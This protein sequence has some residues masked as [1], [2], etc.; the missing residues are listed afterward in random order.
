[1]TTLT[2]TLSVGGDPVT[3]SLWLE[4]SQRA[5]GAGGLNVS[6]ADPYVFR[7]VAGQIAG[8]GSAPYTV[9]GNDTLTP[10]NTWYHVT[11]FGADGGQLLRAS[12]SIT[13]ASADIG[14]FPS[15]STGVFVPP[16][17]YGVALLG[18]AVGLST[19]NT[20]TKIRGK[21]VEAPPWTPGEVMTVQPDGSLGFDPPSGGGGGGGGGTPSGTVVSETA[22]GGS[23]SA[24]SASTYS[25]GDHTH[26]TP[27]APTP[28]SIGAAAASHTHAQADV[29][30]L[31]SDLSAKAPLAS[32]TFTGTPAAPTASVGTNTTQVATTAF[33]QAAA[34]AMRQI[35]QNSQSGAYVVVASDAGKHVYIS[36]GGVTLNASV[37]SAGDAVTIVNNSGSNQTITAGASVTFRLAGT[38]TTG[39]R[40]LAQYGVATFLCVV[41]GA[42]PTYVCTGAGLS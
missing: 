19:S 4:L 5:V 11:V 20:V 23:P 8:P 16:V 27:A 41:G 14:A 38:A 2:G 15:A 1:M 36:T 28:A 39:N 40:T 9:P 26:G 21:A 7:L 35:P 3:G 37:L 31:V 18:D 10:A 29:T 42:S 30:S 34:P 12:V 24:G 13:G 22:F 33:V 25:R 32:P 6:P 17:G